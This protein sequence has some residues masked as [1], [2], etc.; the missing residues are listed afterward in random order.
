[1]RKENKKTSN[2]ER[3]LLIIKPDA[4]RE[5][6]I[7]NIISFLE[8]YDFKITEMRMCHLS[9]EESEFFYNEHRNKPFFSSLVNFFSSSPL[10]ALCLSGNDVIKKMRIIIGNNN[11][12]IA[13]EGTIRKKYGKNI[14]SNAVHSSDSLESAKREISFFFKD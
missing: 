6:N 5:K 13:L 14:E 3:T 1:M 11:P 10:I 4:T 7:G 2:L 12:E 8:K 9:K